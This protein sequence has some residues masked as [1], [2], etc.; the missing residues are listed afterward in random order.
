[1]EDEHDTE[2]AGGDAHVVRGR[3]HEHV[4]GEHG[5]TFEVTSD[6][7]LTPAG[8]CILGVEADSVPADAPS[9]FVDAC[10]DADA[11]ITATFEADGHVETVT[12]RGDPELTFDGDRSWVGRTSDYVDDRTVMVGADAAAADFDRDLVDALAAGAELTVTFR[13]D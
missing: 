1:M 9:A 3:G 4:T 8:D 6:D 11:T 2:A 10:R 12:G 13:V 5:S 7:W